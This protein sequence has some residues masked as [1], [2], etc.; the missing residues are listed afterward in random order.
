MRNVLAR[1]VIIAASVILPAVGHA[2]IVQA[3]DICSDIGKPHAAQ[4]RALN[5]AGFL[6]LDAPSRQLELASQATF[7]VNG[8]NWKNTD[9]AKVLEA[10]EFSGQWDPIPGYTRDVVRLGH[11]SGA[12]IEVDYSSGPFLKGKIDMVV[13]SCLIVV[14]KDYG[15][16]TGLLKFSEHP[17]SKQTDIGVFSSFFGKRPAPLARRNPTDGLKTADL[18]GLISIFA[19]DTG[20]ELPAQAYHIHFTEFRDS[21]E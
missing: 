13:R 16:K 4:M 1:L 18:R 5:K 9:Y 8:S 14:P 20:L 15:G 3:F 6:P 17:K 19:P 10:G 11:P 12:M 7:A 21:S 2:Q